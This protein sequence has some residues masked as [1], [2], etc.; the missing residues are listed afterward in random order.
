MLIDIILLTCDTS[1]TLGHC[2]GKLLGTCPSVL[3]SIVS[4]HYD[5]QHVYLISSLLFIPTFLI[6]FE[7]NSLNHNQAF[8]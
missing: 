6:L 8:S 5:L 2:I 7:K 3:K 4:W 1:A